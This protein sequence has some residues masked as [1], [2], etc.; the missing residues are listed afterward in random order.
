MCRMVNLLLSINMKLGRTENSPSIGLEGIC[1]QYL[2]FRILLGT[3]SIG[4]F[5]T[6]SFITIYLLA[7]KD[8]AGRLPVYFWL[9]IMLTA[10]SGKTYLTLC[11]LLLR[12]PLNSCFRTC[13]QEEKAGADIVSMFNGKPMPLYKYYYY[14][15]L[16]T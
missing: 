1:I 11:N 10:L 6:L 4:L 5:L 3:I 7:N 9:Q 14:V 2:A 16:S 15:E 12:I 8:L 13:D